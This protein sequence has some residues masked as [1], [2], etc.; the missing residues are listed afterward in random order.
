M[1]EYLCPVCGSSVKS[2]SGSDYGRRFRI[3]CPRCGQYEITSSSISMLERLLQDTAT[4]SARLSHAI[5]M[6]PKHG[7]EWF[8]VTSTNCGDLVARALPNIDGQINNLLTWLSSQVGDD[9]LGRI[10]LKDDT[11]NNLAGIIGAVDLDRVDRLLKFAVNEDLI[12]V[13]YGREM[14]LQPKGL[15]LLQQNQEPLSDPSESS[16]PTIHKEE[17]AADTNEKILMANCNTCGGEK[18]SFLRGEHV[19]HG[20]D[21][22]TSWS[23]TIKILECCGCG[24]LSMS[25]QHWF[26]EWDEIDQDPITGEMRMRPGVK[27]VLWPPTN[28]RSKPDWVDRLKDKITRKVIDE[29]YTALD[30]GLTILA[31]IGTRTLLDRAMT[32][33]V[34]D[35][36]TFDRKLKAMVAN[37]RMN[38]EE[39]DIFMVMVDVGSAAT[40]RAHS[41]TSKTLNKVLTAAE[42][43]LLREFIMPMD[44]VDVKKE[45]PARPK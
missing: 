25:H 21:D 31:A 19:K 1:T 5:R 36:G 28:S 38:A 34:G 26:S 10:L 32:M 30:H 22:W 7:D 39:K 12:E 42:S 20:S 11:L 16:P 23:D 14:G 15:K 29:I 43:L 6:Q 3:D 2:Q 37:Q 35:A 17:D 33:K 4:A 41:P 8:L 9:H 27:E 40:H 44:A 18:N 45:T 24:G 13:P